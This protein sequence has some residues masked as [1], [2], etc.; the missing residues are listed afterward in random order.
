MREQ[1][2][3]PAGEEFQASGIG[4]LGGRGG[5]RPG[6]NGRPAHDEGEDRS[7]SVSEAVR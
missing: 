7:E 3:E 4:G 5:Q 6:A 1:G 2:A